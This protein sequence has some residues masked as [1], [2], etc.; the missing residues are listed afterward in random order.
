MP[1]AALVV[2]LLQVGAATLTTGGVRGTI[3][4]EATGEPLAGVRVE[5]LDVPA[6]APVQSDAA[7]GYALRG[8]SL[9][10]HRLRFVAPGYETLGIDVLLAGEAPLRLDASLDRGPARLAP[11]QVLASTSSADVARAGRAP[12][13]P[14]AWHRTGE[15]LRSSPA[16]DEADAFRLLATAPQA[17][18]S[19]EASAG[20]HVRGGSADQNRFLL[21]GAPVFSPVHSGALLSAF[22]PDIVDGLLVHGGAPS[23]AYGGSLSS[24]IDVHTPTSLAGA[25]NARG[26]FGATALRG[27]LQVPLIAGRAGLLLSARHSYS[28]LRREN[29]A[30]SRMPGAWSDL[31]GKLTLRGAADDLTLSSFASEDGLGFPAAPEPSASLGTATA[32]ATNRFEWASTTHAVTWRHRLRTGGALEARTWSSRFVAG[33]AWSP[34]SGAL[35]LGSRLQSNGVSA[36]VARPNRAGQLTMGVELERLATDYDLTRPSPDST[37]DVAA[38]VLRLTAAPTLGSLFAEQRWWLGAGWRASAGVRGTM[39]PHARPRIEPR[40][41]VGYQPNDRLTFLAGYARLHQYSQSLRNEESLLGSVL[42]LDLPVAMGAPNV[43]VGRS[44]DFTA[45][46]A[47]ALPAATRLAIDA[48]ARRLTGLVLVAPATAEPFATSRFEVGDGRAAGIG[49]SISRDVGRLTFL[50][51]YAVATVTRRSGATRYHPTFAPTHSASISVG[52]RLLARTTLRSAVWA[53]SGRPT[54]ALGDDIG[55][56]AGDLL[57]GT[58]ELSGTPQHSA[59]PLDGDRL[60]TYVRMDVGVRHTLP[61]R[62]SR[63]ALTGVASLTNTLGRENTAAYVLTTSGARHG[64]VMLPPSLVL[65]LEWHY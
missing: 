6:P 3:R 19:P 55:W 49:G 2:L 54:T 29:I 11:M 33:A 52:Y 65:G 40:L 30:E 56:D 45:S 31:F 24:I 4:S 63:G 53:S 22:S 59:G 23:A 35:A 38:P 15:G 46:A 39:T 20:V 7:G 13:D 57:S 34:D 25:P 18:M 43:P 8:M 62:R 37:T 14:S 1:S 28:G 41:T 50:G 61:L 60:P 17:Q 36:L 32:G 51:T 47:I 10:R 9:G 64:L 5:V 42:G 44:D 12:S 27:A 48:Y 58:R 26:A 21:D 16:L